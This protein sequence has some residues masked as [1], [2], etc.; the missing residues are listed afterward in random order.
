MSD[1]VSSHS[2]AIRRV[3]RVFSR[4]VSLLLLSISTTGVYATQSQTGAPSSAKPAVPHKSARSH[5]RNNAV[6]AANAAVPA[7]PVQVIAAP[8]L[9]DWPANEN[10]GQPK[11]TWDSHGLRIDAANSSLRQILN[12]VA[13]VT[14]AKV[15]GMGA[16]ERVFGEF[17]PGQARDVLS[18]LLHGSSYNV[19]MIGDQGQGTPRQIVLSSR[20][21]GGAAPAASG[22]PLQESPEDDT[23]PEAEPTPPPAQQPPPGTT[24]P[25]TSMP[26]FGPR[27]TPQQ[28]LQQIQQR[29]QEMQNSQ[30][31]PQ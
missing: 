20:H 8:V 5:V 17:G 21:A 30:P 15:E 3:G 14:G 7:A 23:E 12:N 11:V 18:Q 28:M 13:T 16:D 1:S 27:T 19:L 25:P 29:Q 6:P 4:T 31:P 26:Q 22:R 10:P 2:I 9:P 24:R